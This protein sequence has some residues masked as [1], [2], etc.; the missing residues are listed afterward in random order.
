MDADAVTPLRRLIELV[1]PPVRPHGTRGD[2]ALAERDLGWQVPQHVLEVLA[3]YGSVTFLGWLHLPSPFVADDVAALRARRRGLERAFAGAR[4]LLA[5]SDPAGTWLFAG[6][7]GGISVAS[8]GEATHSGWSLAHFLCSWL[9]GAERFGL[10][11]LQDIT[12]ADDIPPFA[13]PQWDSQRPSR[14]AW[15]FVQGGAS[16]R[17]ER[18]AAL[19]EALGAHQ[20]CARI[21][22]GEKRQDR[23]FV[24]DLEA[25][26]FYDSYN[27]RDGVEQIHVR[28][29]ED[30]KGDVRARLE[31]ML[32]NAGMSLV[33]MDSPRGPTSW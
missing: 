11:S 2:T 5:F 20:A 22:E 12:G 13:T 31:T 24:G 30:R 18:W 33:R 4:S 6:A 16:T 19:R 23:V 9:T 3:I 25:D 1:P 26:V 14:I 10:P 17:A 32:A 29:Y 21:G 27:R 7:D 15:M 28:F 8:E